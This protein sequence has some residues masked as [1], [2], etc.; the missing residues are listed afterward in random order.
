M[1][2]QN[3]NVKV[4]GEETAGRWGGNPVITAKH[5]I[6]QG[7]DLP[8]GVTLFCACVSRHGDIQVEIRKHG[9][10]VWRAWS[11]EPEFLPDLERNLRDV[12]HR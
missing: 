11:F 1:H 12:R 9:S 10:L 6:R 4:A 2:T 7:G 8:D 5:L 3:V